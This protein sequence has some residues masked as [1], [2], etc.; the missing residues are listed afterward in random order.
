MT[1]TDLIV[2]D[3]LFV[4]VVTMVYETDGLKDYPV[5]LGPFMIIAFIT[6]VVRHI[7]YYHIHKKI[8]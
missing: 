5:I 1:R 3:S 8:Y 2:A 6:C 4:I 7:N